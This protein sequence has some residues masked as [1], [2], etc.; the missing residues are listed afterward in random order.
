MRTAKCLWIGILFSLVVFSPFGFP[1]QITSLLDDRAFAAD[2]N[3]LA[4]EE[5]A[6]HAVLA[7]DPYERFNRDMFELNDQIYFNLLKP[8][9]LVYSA[10]FPTGFR[11]AVKN[12]FYNIMFA[13]RF[14]NSVLQGKMGKAGTETVRFL[15]NSTMGVGGLFDVAE[16]NFNIQRPAGEDFGQTLAVWG[17]GPGPF[18][19]VP[20]FGP[21][22]PRDLFGY[23]V[24]QTMDPVF[25]IPADW[26]VGAAVSGG[27]IINRTSLIIGEYEDFKKSAIDPYV[28]MRDAYTQH[29]REEINH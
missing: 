14:I 15:I 10:Y 21:S 25:W 4:G 24:D 5:P 28:S 7:Y 6:D 18:L 3:N 26:W 27:K 8:T 9:S 11:V 22:N 16:R 2:G 23:A 1:V 19:M 20:V 29:R 17:L 13:S 12:G